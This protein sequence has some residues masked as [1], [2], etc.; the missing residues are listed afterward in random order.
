MLADAPY[1]TGRGGAG[2]S[3]SPHAPFDPS[4]L[5]NVLPSSSR[6]RPRPRRRHR[7]SIGNMNSSRSRSR[8]RQP[9]LT[10]SS[11]SGPTQPHAAGPLHNLLHG[12]GGKNGSVVSGGAGDGG[13]LSKTTSR[14]SSNFMASLARGGC[15]VGLQVELTWSCC[16][17]RRGTKTGKWTRRVWEY[18]PRRSDVSGTTSSGQ[19]FRGRHLECGPSSWLISCMVAYFSLCYD[20]TTRTRQFEAEKLSDAQILSRYRSVHPHEIHSSGRGGGG[21]LAA[22]LATETEARMAA[23]SLEDREAR[24]K[25]DAESARLGR[26]TGH[27]GIGNYQPAAPIVEVDEEGGGRGRQDANGGGGMMRKVL[28]SMSRQ[29]GT[30]DRSAVRS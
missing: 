13:E 23:I 16:G 3:H 4:Q 22:P 27:G 29:S 8:S 21:N 25:V 20:L 9:S 12:K 14:S 7:L 1:S 6:P 19:S 24:D 18:D 15:S 10:R 11:T 30:R 26:T 2:E 28:R 17:D 5:L